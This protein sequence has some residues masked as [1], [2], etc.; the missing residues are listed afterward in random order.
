LRVPAAT[1]MTA[2]AP[3]ARTVALHAPSLIANVMPSS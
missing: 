2:S 1:A 3:R